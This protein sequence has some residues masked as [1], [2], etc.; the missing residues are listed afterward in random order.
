MHKHHSALGLATALVKTTSGLDIAKRRPVQ[1]VTLVRPHAAT[2]AARLL[3]VAKHIERIGDY[4]KDICELNV[5]LREAVFI[6]HS[7][8]H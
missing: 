4:V 5:Y 7:A 1:P 2:R 6:K 3:F 8:V